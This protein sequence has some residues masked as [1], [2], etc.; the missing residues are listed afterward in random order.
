M[1]FLFIYLLFSHIEEISVLSYNVPP[2]YPRFLNRFFFHISPHA[3]TPTLQGS[4][5]YHR[6]FRHTT[7]QSHRLRG[8]APARLSLQQ[9]LILPVQHILISYHLMDIILFT[10]SPESST[11]FFWI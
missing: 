11:L 2:I 3:E 5:T 6:L 10:N 4:H 8:H 7:V 9:Q 1:I